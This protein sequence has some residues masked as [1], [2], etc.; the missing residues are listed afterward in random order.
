MD[1]IILQHCWICEEKFQK[2]G[3][4]AVFNSHHLVPVAYGGVDGPQIT[5]CTSDHNTLHLIAVAWKGT[6]PHYNYVK[7]RNSEHTKKLEYLASIVYNAELQSRND[8]NKSA[9][10]ILHLNARQ[11]MMIDRLKKVYPNLSS[12]PNVLLAA[13]ENLYNKHFT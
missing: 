3:G 12:R 2:Y 6:K 8:P 13:L 7:N 1:S 4:T 11:K 5:L 10:V 9:A